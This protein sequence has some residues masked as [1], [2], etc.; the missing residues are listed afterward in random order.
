MG[1]LYIE[2]ARRVNLTVTRDN[3]RLKKK[4]KNNNIVFRSLPWYRYT[5]AVVYG[6]N[7][8]SPYTRPVS[9]PADLSPECVRNFHTPTCKP[10][11]APRNNGRARVCY[12]AVVVKVPPT[13]YKIRYTDD[14]FD[15]FHY[16]FFISFFF[17]KICL[18]IVYFFFSFIILEAA[19][20]RESFFK[21]LYADIYEILPR[22]KKIPNPLRVPTL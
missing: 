17:F 16:S 6:H 8:P 4:K 13:S 15:V 10:P 9:L 21:H 7:T 19:N 11:V 1:R 22:D 14:I 12:S 18:A 20:K 3:V 5:R 2:E